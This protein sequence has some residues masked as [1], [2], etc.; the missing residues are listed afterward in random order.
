MRKFHWTCFLLLLSSC[1]SN[2]QETLPVIVGAERLDQY[3]SLIEG[4]RIG[5]T[6]NH[7]SIIR[8]THLVDT[9]EYYTDVKKVFTP[10][11]GFS[12]RKSDG[13]E[14]DYDQANQSYELISLYGKNKKPTDDQLQGIELMILDIQDVGA[15][16]YTY[17]STLH[18]VME[19]CAENDVPLIVLDRPNPNASYIDGP[20]LDTAFSSFVG[21]HPI[22]IIYGLTMGELAKMINEEGW[23]KSA[24]HCDLTVI[25][26]KNWSHSTKYSLP[27]KPSP[28]LP[29]DLSIALYP[30]LCLFEG[31]IM[32][33]GR[34]TPHAF[35]QIGHPKYPDTTHS[36]IPISNEGAR[37][38]PFENQ[39]CYGVSWFNAD[40]TY[41]F[42]LSPLIDAYQKMDTTAFFNSYFE[43]LSGT[44]QLREQIEEGLSEKE[45]RS[46]WEVDLKMYREKRLKYLLYE[47]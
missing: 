44:D 32:S 47:E 2:S 9:L 1:I 13:E 15:R 34:G 11:H 29:N 41:A 3:Q 17:I 23:L 19:A 37:W 4:K 40:T 14:I 25:P 38:P 42:S 26:L 46:S 12:G 35:Q 45:I 10:E 30:S 24:I 43:K 31:T 22:P 16:F 33:V 36:F 5:L 6:V 18:Y 28:N 7:S 21:M 39:Q 27:V 20:V 8:N